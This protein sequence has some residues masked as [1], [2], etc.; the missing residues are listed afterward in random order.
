M[1]IEL[2]TTT[3]FDREYKRLRKK[4]VQD[5]LTNHN[6]QLKAGKFEQS[7]NKMSYNG[8]ILERQTYTDPT[9]GDVF[10]DWL[11]GRGNFVTVPEEVTLE[12]DK[13]KQTE[14]C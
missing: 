2:I 5:T 9:T 11:D 10:D 13:Q 8:Q 14:I 4:I 3:I 12:W 6:N 1:K 7:N